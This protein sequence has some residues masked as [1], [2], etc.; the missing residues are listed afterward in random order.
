MSFDQ[1][2][3]QHFLCYGVRPEYVAGHNKLLL[4][5][6]VLRSEHSRQ[7]TLENPTKARIYPKGHM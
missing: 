7:R 4:I 2:A 1:N 3:C 6:C 5:H